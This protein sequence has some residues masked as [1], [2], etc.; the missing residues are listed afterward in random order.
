MGTRKHSKPGSEVGLK[1]TE[2]ERQLLLDLTCLDDN[3]AQVI[4]GTP[5]D[6]PVQF[7][8][9]EWEDFGDYIA[10]EANHAEDRRQEK[11]LDALFSK[12]RNLLDTQVEEQPPVALKVH[13]PEED[14][15]AA[16]ADVPTLPVNLTHAQRKV[17][18]NVLS[19]L[20]DRLK[21]DE[22]ASRTI[23]FTLNELQ[24]IITKCQAAVPNASGMVR[25]SFRH[26][27]EAAA[28][29]MERHKEGGHIPASERL[30][31]FKITLK[32]IRPP[33][34]RRIQVKD[35]T[36]DKLHE[37]I[38]TAMGWESY[39]DY[40]F[41]IHGICYGDS[42]VWQP[43]YED[44]RDASVVRLSTFVSESGK[45]F[46]FE[47][48]HEFGFSWEHDIL[49][50][51]CLLANQRACCPVCLDGERACPLEDVGGPHGY[52]VYLEAMADPDHEHHQE[53]MACRGPYD[54]EK[55]DAQAVTK[56]MRRGLPNWREME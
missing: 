53:F 43:E 38:Q 41:S 50:E 5:P 4:K 12:I 24:E 18:A 14:R 40:R 26:I 39:Y 15:P 13:R 20:N 9:D 23:Q 16:K 11:R 33:I 7:T 31:Q 55:F 34:W 56:R 35:C 2:A 37:H 46:R 19:A 17:L 25:N 44:I 29:A 45:R 47:Y 1:L 42:Q 54:A 22:A 36:L 10:A 30:Y 6:Q 21:I 49:F 51:G 27:T 8:L 28:K 32:D 52:Q 3:Y 48:R